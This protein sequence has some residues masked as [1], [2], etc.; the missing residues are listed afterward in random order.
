[1]RGGALDR[2]S[3]TKER[4]PAFQFY[5]RQFSGDDQVMAMDLDAIGAHILLMCNAAASPE[6]Y[7][8]EADERAIRNRVRNP[9]D[10][11][12][13]RIRAQ[14][15][16]GAWKPTTDGLWWEQ[17]GLRRAHE[18]QQAFS[19]AQR[20]RAGARWNAERMPDVVPDGCR[21]DAGS[22]AGAVPKTC[23]SSS[24]SISIYSPTPFADLECDISPEMVA[25][26]VKQELGLGG[27]HVA[28]CLVDI[29]R[30]KLNAGAD[31]TKLR[32]DLVAAWTA[33][34]AA[35]EKLEWT[36]GSPEKF[37]ASDKWHDPKLWPWKNGYP[38]RRL[39]A[40]GE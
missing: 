8:I 40:V 6:R 29:C 24:S 26:G 21:T 20:S 13:K 37:Y 14:L 32:N 35:S 12:W 30:A 38:S 16:R 17:E 39:Q 9:G 25:Q 23:S 28:V 18:K 11:D 34:K 1:M 15:L 7:R 36:Y 10:R 4:A 27:V 31:P 22:D 2:I 3:K 33:Y 19:D 5:P